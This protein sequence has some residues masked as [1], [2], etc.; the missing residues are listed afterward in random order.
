MHFVVGLRSR[1]DLQQDLLIHVS[2]RLGDDNGKELARDYCT[3]TP[4]A[5][6]SVAQTE[7]P[8]YGMPLN[9]FAG[10]SPP[11]GSV[12]PT[13]DEPVKPVQP[14]GQT[15]ASVTGSFDRSLRPVRPVRWWLGQ[16]HNH[17][18][19]LFPLRLSLAE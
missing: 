10:Q 14:T 3:G 6:S 12:R 18:S 8:Q 7:N 16:R 2:M 17:S 19:P 9:Y 1:K 5:S 11:P 13:M 4:N 15:G